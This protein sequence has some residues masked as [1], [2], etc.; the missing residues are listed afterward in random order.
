[1]RSLWPLLREVVYGLKL[2]AQRDK[3]VSAYEAE[4]EGSEKM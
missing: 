2:R 1:M 3:E 4:K